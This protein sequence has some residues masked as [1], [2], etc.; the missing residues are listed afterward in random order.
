MVNTMIK[1]VTRL[2]TRVLDPVRPSTG[3]LRRDS[4]LPPSARRAPV[5][6]S[7]RAP[8]QLLLFPHAAGVSFR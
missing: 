1:P 7:G 4:A 2:A 8:A 6:H 5:L 3:T